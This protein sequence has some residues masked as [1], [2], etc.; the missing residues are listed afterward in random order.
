MRELIEIWDSLQDFPKDDPALN[1][2]IE[3]RLSSRMKRIAEDIKNCASKCDNF[4]NKPVLGI[5]FS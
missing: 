4:Q 3:L 2:T 1:K 5:V